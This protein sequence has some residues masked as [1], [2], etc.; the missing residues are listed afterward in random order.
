MPLISTIKTFKKYVRVAFTSTDEAGLPNIETAERKYLLPKLGSTLYNALV[1]EVNSTITNLRLVDICRA[2]IAPMAMLDQLPNR[3]VVITDA[4]I[5]KTTSQDQEN[6]FRWEYEKLEASLLEQAAEAENDLWDYLFA[7]ATTLPWENPVSEKM[8][9]KSGSEFKKYY[10]SLAQTSRNFAALQP[11]LVTV[12]D[13]YF[14]NA[15]TPEFFTHLI[16]VAAPNADEKAAL[17][18]LKKSAVY[19]TISRACQLL[20]VSISASGFNVLIQGT[21]DL[22]KPGAGAA[23]ATTLSSL[24]SGAESV[25]LTYLSELK[26]LLN[27]KAS[28]LIYPLYFSS[29]AYSDPAAVKDSPN[30]N[31]KGI[32]SL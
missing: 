16:T 29:S 20:P 30:K 3:Q 32:F 24:K 5:K 23:N 27:Q 14:K 12:Q 1:A 11:I 8:A 6:V 17:D 18:L 21:P 2:Y 19:L 4:G 15:I 26:T 13:Q 9:I 22:D 25:G 10:Q 7:N 28:A 31:R